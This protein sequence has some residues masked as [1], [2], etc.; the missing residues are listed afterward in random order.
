MKEAAFMAAS[1]F[2]DCG[3]RPWAE[4]IP[5]PSRFEREFMAIPDYQTFMLPVLRATADG[6]DHQMKEVISLLID[7]YDM[8]EEEKTQLLPS[9]TA[10]KTLVRYMVDQNV[11]V[12]TV[13]RYELKSTDCDYF[14]ME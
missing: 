5:S 3:L 8:T 9:G 10:G 4:L 2:F 11:G 6:H 13:G 14:E 1:L 7:N 12:S